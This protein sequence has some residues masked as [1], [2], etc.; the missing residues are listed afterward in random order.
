MSEHFDIIAHV[1]TL[2]K[3]SPVM[4][5]VFNEFLQRESHVKETADSIEQ[6]RR[7]SVERYI[8]E[9]RAWNSFRGIHR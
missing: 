2:P 8:L 3:T 7:I 5:R 6:L 1:V 9:Q 4:I